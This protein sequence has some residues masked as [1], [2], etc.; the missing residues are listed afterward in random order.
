[1][2]PSQ[3]LRTLKKG[4][5]TSEAPELRASATG[6]RFVRKHVPNVVPLIAPREVWLHRLASRAQKTAATPFTTDILRTRVSWGCTA[7]DMVYIEGEPGKVI[8]HP[9]E[10]AELFVSIER[11]S[12][13]VLRKEPTRLA[14]RPLHFTSYGAR[15][16]RYDLGVLIRALGPVMALDELRPGLQA[17]LLALGRLFDEFDAASAESGTVLSHL[18]PYDAN[19]IR[20]DGRLQLIDWGEAYLGRVGFEAG[21]YLMRLLRIRDE[22]KMLDQARVILDRYRNED[23]LTPEDI[24]SMPE[25]INRVFVPRS[26]W[27]WLWPKTVERFQREDRLSDLRARL[28]FLIDCGKSPPWRAYL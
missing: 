18:D 6:R 12:R 1:M 9:E 20:T 21:S 13:L 25:A 17:D 28:E 16:R 4:K 22:T 23:W 8:D 15:R 24:Q 14:M 19:V 11:S 26:L 7:I 10:L 2:P 3:L 27:Y 5:S